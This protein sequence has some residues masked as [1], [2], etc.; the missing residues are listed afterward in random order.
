LG[1]GVEEPCISWGGSGGGR[2]RTTTL[3]Y[4]PSI[5]W[6]VGGGGRLRTTTL[7]Y[8][9]SIWPAPKAW[10]SCA[11]WHVFAATCLLTWALCVL[12]VP[13]A[14]SGEMSADVR[15]NF[16]EACV[17]FAN[18]MWVEC[19]RV[20]VSMCVCVWVC[21]WVDGG[22][23]VSG[24]MSGVAHAASNS[25]LGYPPL[26]PRPSRYTHILPPPTHAACARCSPSSSPSAHWLWGASGTHSSCSR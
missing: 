18:H 3:S 20:C 9:P 11:R 14:C 21:G 12:C 5:S 23:C 17:L 8:L 24:K 19:V 22:V 6:G 25:S 15:S 4:L 1:G 16:S 10:F 26:F 7:S 2:L 13:R